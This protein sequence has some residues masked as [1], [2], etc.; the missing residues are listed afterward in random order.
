MLLAAK[1]PTGGEWAYKIKRDSYRLAVHI[2]RGRFRILTRGGHN[3]TSRFRAIAHV[4][5][6]MALDRAILNGEAVVPDER[7]ASDFLLS[8]RSSFMTGSPVIVDGGM[9]VRLVDPQ[10]LI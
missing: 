1:P 8:D 4:A 2:E 9:S 5:L 7:G 6:E 3:W 10:R